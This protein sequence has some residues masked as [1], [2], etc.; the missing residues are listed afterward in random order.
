MG[1]V[2]AD[3]RLKGAF[4]NFTAELN[5]MKN[6]K[7]YGNHIYYS[8]LKM[9]K[10]LRKLGFLANN[11]EFTYRFMEKLHLFTCYGSELRRIM[12]EAIRVKDEFVTVEERLK[13]TFGI[14]IPD[15]FLRILA[16]YLS[17][18]DLPLE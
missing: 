9:S 1:K 17:V 4:E 7:F 8:V 15:V 13:S 12:N 6:T 3:P 16:E 14:F 18:D 11:L 2:F 10:N 5:R